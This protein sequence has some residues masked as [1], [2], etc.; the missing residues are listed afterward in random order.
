MAD[1]DYIYDP[2]D[3][4]WTAAWGDR[5]TLTEECKGLQ[6]PRDV[7]RFATLIDG[8]SKFAAIVPLTFTD[9]GEPDETEVRWFDTEA[10]ART[11]CGM[12][13]YI[14]AG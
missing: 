7:K 4:E 13:P 12:P 5:V 6:R 14:G 10:E 11:A 2:D 1:P 9:D 3:W 8:P